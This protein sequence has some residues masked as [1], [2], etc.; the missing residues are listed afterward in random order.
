MR[1]TIL[2]HFFLA[3][4]SYAQIDAPENS[5]EELKE[6]L[7]NGLNPDEKIRINLQ[8]CKNQYRTDTT[9]INYC[10]EAEKLIEKNGGY[11]WELLT[12]Y[13][14]IGV[15]HAIR[16][17]HN[18]ALDYFS[19]R[20]RIS[21]SLNVD[22]VR[23]D[24][25]RFIGNLYAIQVKYD[26]A[27]IYYR[28][29]Q[30]LLSE[31]EEKSAPLYEVMANVILESGGD[32]QEAIQYYRIAIDICNELDD[33]Q[34]KANIYLNLA[35]SFIRTE[36]YDSAIYYNKESI[37][38]ARKF[39]NLQIEGVANR[40]TGIVLRETGEYENALVYLKNGIRILE[41][42]NYKRGLA[43]AYDLTGST[44]EK[45]GR[46]EE[47]E[48]W[49]AKGMKLNKELG[50]LGFYKEGLLFL[51]E[52]EIQRG[53]FRAALEH[54]KVYDKIEDSLANV[55]R[56]QNV[57]KLQV[58]FETAAKEQ[59]IKLLEKDKEISNLWKTGLTVGLILSIAVGL[60]LFLFQKTRRNLAESK[61]LLSQKEQEYLEQE[62]DYKNREIVNFAV[63]IS[64]RDRLV[65][66]INDSIRTL[67]KKGKDQD[68]I[69]YL[70]D[71]IKS[72]MS[73]SKKR[74]EFEVHVQQVY[75]SFFKKLEI[76]YPDLTLSEKRLAA[77]LRV[78]LSSKEIAS[79]VNISPKSVDMN[80]YRLR[81][82][83]RLESEENLTEILQTI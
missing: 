2:F 15:A 39:N 27:L 6:R 62:L 52:I 51:H 63:E 36:E 12:L 59:Q 17:N 28:K 71:T 80:R 18:E 81:K 34:E 22:T 64:E 9:G 83:M 11:E 78:N 58:E 1:L 35:N 65:E 69:D 74:D 24:T 40:Q 23:T 26:S 10:Y 44:Y 37:K 57:E 32:V 49:I 72:F 55:V 8:L 61:N 7:E 3:A 68:N 33:P 70:V 43:E 48:S 73:L 41:T 56:A 50:Y 79:V 82:K 16:G 21:K 67:E 76:T 29:C 5:I 46:L 42:I 66:K 45:L 31:M 4:H 19:K 25:Y 54:Y 77:L 13:Y 60:V 38:M 14:H 47:A 75:Q 20:L 30:E 53:N